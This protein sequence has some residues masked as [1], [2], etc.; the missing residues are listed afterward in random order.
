[1]SRVL[2]GQPGSH[3]ANRGSPPIE[4]Y[5]QRVEKTRCSC[6]YKRE[7]EKK[8]VKFSVAKW[9]PKACPG[10]FG[11]HVWLWGCRISNIRSCSK[12]PPVLSITLKNMTEMEKWFLKTT[13]WGSGTPQEDLQSQLTW[14]QWGA[15]RDWTND[16]AWAGPR[17]PIHL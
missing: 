13:F 8:E 14:A 6:Q 4:S 10:R 16:Y 12:A 17:S 3:I 1:M 2:I 5:V 11:N 7:R 9:E 15:H